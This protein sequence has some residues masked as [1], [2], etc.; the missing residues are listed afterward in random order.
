MYFFC[1]SGA[2]AVEC[3][4]KMIRKYQ[5]VKGNSNKYRII[6]FEGSFHGR[7]MA[8]ISAAKK[9]KVMKG[10]EPAL[11]GF[12]QVPFDDIEA[13]KAAIT[14]QT[15]GILIEPIL[16]EGGIRPASTAFIERATRSLR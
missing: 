11:D 9:D 4:I 6:T 8:T 16:G 13:V 3:T 12:D 10:F 1:N 2:E 15:A 7:T 5:S 14:S